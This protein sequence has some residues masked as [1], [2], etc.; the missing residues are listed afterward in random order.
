MDLVSNQVARLWQCLPKAPH[1]SNAQRKC[2]ELKFEFRMDAMKERGLG[3][4]I[5]SE[6]FQLMLRHMHPGEQCG[7]LL[8]HRSPDGCR[9]LRRKLRVSDGL[10]EN[11]ISL[12]A[13]IEAE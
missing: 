5:E 11:V 13:K 10:S 3:D 4:N 12:V 1:L 9:K 2:R 7:R 8:W 6:F